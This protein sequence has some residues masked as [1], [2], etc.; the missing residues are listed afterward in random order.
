ME[1]LTETAV[2]AQAVNQVVESLGG[3]STKKIGWEIVPSAELPS[4]F[5]RGPS[6]YRGSSFTFGSDQGWTNRVSR[7]A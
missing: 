6:R 2:E 3:S 1:N 4:H 5:Y 7:S